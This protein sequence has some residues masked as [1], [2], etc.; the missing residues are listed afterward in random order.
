MLLSIAKEKQPYIHLVTIAILAPYQNAHHL[1]FNQQPQK[2]HCMMIMFKMIFTLIV[3]SILVD[4]KNNTTNTCRFKPQL[5]MKANHTH[6]VMEVKSFFCTQYKLNTA[7]SY[8]L[9][10][11]NNHHTS[12]FVEQIINCITFKNNDQDT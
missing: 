11:C 1:L 9:L 10:V 8:V 4:T 5:L 7:V 2:L 6:T 3:Y 12:L